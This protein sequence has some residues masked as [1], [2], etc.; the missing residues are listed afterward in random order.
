MKFIGLLVGLGIGSLFFIQ[1]SSIAQVDPTSATLLRSSGGHVDQDSLDSSRYK[2]RPRSSNS[3]K[4]TLGD[5]SSTKSTKEKNSLYSENK[6][7]KN[8]VNKENQIEVKDEKN[9]QVSQSDNANAEITNEDDLVLH[10]DDFRWNLVELGVGTGVFYQNSDSNYWYRKYFTSGPMLTTQAKVWLSE[11]IGVHGQFSTSLAS[12]VTGNVEGTNRVPMDHQWWL[13]GL[14]YRKSFTLS[15]LSPIVLWGLSFSESK[16]NVP[17]NSPQRIKLRSSGVAVSVNLLKP[18]SYYHQWDLG[19]LFQPRSGQ[20]EGATGIDVQSGSKGQNYLVEMWLGSRFL[21][22]GKN[23]FFWK[24]SHTLESSIYEGEAN[25]IDPQT[26][27]TPEGVYVR[28]ST[29]LLGIGYVW[30][31]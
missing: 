20:S 31:E 14:S 16:S 30:G 23:Q 1:I 17:A 3:S 8:I 15:R 9:Q 19:V 18:S 27:T 24:L 22:N 11:S 7:N 2:V 6:S 29:T 25:Q 4:E 5:K 10:P 13:A 28:K 26:Q 21:L 12:D